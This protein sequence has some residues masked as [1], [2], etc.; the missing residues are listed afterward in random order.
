MN[1]ART[2]FYT[3]IATAARLLA[4]LVAIKLV[5]WFAGP[6]GVGKLGQFMSLMSLLAVLAGGGISS[7]IVKYVAEYRDD[8]QRLSRL[9]SAALWYAF[10]ASCLMGGLALLLS[11]QLALWLLDDDAVDRVIAACQSFACPP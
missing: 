9:L 2:G 7:A 5:A 3:S 4:G 8:P 6:E 1:I 11:R 10:L